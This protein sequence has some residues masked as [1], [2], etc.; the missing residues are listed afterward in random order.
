MYESGLLSK[1]PKWLFNI[2][3]DSD[4][5]HY[6]CKCGLF[7][8]WS[9]MEKKLFD[10]IHRWFADQIANIFYSDIPLLVFDELSWIPATFNLLFLILIF[11]ACCNIA[12]VAR[13][14]SMNKKSVSFII[15]LFQQISILLSL[16]LSLDSWIFQLLKAV[17]DYDSENRFNLYF[18]FLSNIFVLWTQLL[19]LSLTFDRFLCAWKPMLYKT[20]A[21]R[22]VA[23]ILSFVMF[24]VSLCI[25]SIMIFSDLNLNP[26]HIV[27]LDFAANFI[28][29]LIISLCL[30]FQI[31]FLVAFLLIF[32]ERAN[33]PNSQMRQHHTY[34]NRVMISTSA[35]ES[36]LSLCH[37]ANRFSFAFWYLTLYLQSSY[38]SSELIHVA[39][40]T[41]LLA[42]PII[43][44]AP[45]I[46]MLLYMTLSPMYRRAFASLLCI[47][48]KAS[49]VAP[50]TS[51]RFES[52]TSTN[53]NK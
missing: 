20:K 42:P 23:L 38:L 31:G 19:S 53:T 7:G 45:F 39:L 36:L 12:I 35:V 25:S 11:I 46:V 49:L 10:L 4:L 51:T 8:M 33:Q 52:K 27:L 13:L 2:I 26:V 43:G 41:L 28:T 29:G 22:K 9:K 24:F 21:T 47:K 32:K 17:I 6:N 50:T 5:F 15:Q 44:C 16:L 34:L 18:L 48:L 37:L 14:S 40:A 30:I 1:Y 3:E